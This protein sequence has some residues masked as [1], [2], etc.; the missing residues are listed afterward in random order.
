VDSSAGVP[1]RDGVADDVHVDEGL[2]GDALSL[3]DST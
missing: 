1:L 3:A 2:A